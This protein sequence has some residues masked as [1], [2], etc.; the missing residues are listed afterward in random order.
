MA[1]IV[2]A[3]QYL[4]AATLANTKGISPSNPNLLGEGS[5]A[6][7]LEAGRNALAVPGV[8]VSSA[9]R[10]LNDQ[11]LSRSADINELFSY[12]AGPNATIEGMQQQILAIRAG[13]SQ[14]QLA[15]EL[16]QDSGATAA[17]TN[18]S[19]VDTEA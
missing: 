5:T 6:S 12:G 10:A 16:Q 18:G 17:G 14:S 7:L 13:L 8:G 4:N 3:S 15:P 11:L 19:A 2:G 1:L 9:A